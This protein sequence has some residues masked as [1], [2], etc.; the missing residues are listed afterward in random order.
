[1]ALTKVSSSLVS[2]SAVTSGKIA[3]GGV[4]TADIATNAVTSTKIAQNS[5]LTKHIDDGQVTTDQLG[6]DA[7][8]AAKIADNAVSEEHLDITVIT[9]LTAVTAATGDLLMVADVSDSNNLKKIPVSSILAGTH[10]GA[11]NTSGTINSGALGVTGNIAV[12]G[13]VDGI[14]IATRDAVLTSTTTTA[15]AALPKAG[16]TMTGSLVLG[17]ASGTYSHELKFTNGS[18]QAGID[19]QNN[20]DLRF[21]DR[22]SNRVGGYISALNGNFGAYNTSNALTNLLNTNGNSY[23]NGG[24]VGIGTNNPNSTVGIVDIAGAATNY[25]TA[26]MITFEDTAGS[27]N[28]RNWS[29]GN[30]A[31]NYGDFHIGCGDTNS[32]YFD[33]TSHSKFM[34]NKDGNVGIADTTPDQKLVVKNGNI[35]L[36]SNSD[37]NTGIVMFYDATGASSGQIYPVGGDLR[38][39]SPNDVLMMPTGNIGIGTTSPS[40]RLQVNASS[41]I[42]D[43]LI[44]KLDGGETGFSSANDA[45]IKHGLS[46]ELCSYSVST[47]IVQRQAA[48]IEVQKVGSWNEATAGNVGTKADLV[49]STNNGTIATPA[50]AER[51]RID[52]SGNVGIGAT[53]ANSS[54]L[55]LDNGGTSGA[56]QLMLTATGASTQTEIR[57]D[58]SNNLI[59]ENWNSGRTERMRID[60]SGTMILQADGAANLGRIQFSNQA[61][62]YQILG[63]NYIGYM[64]YK[65][66]GYHRWFGSDTAE[67][68]RID[69][70]GN[71]GIGVT[72]PDSYDSRAEK[73]VVGE[74][75][76]AGITIA[77]GASSDCRLVFAV[78]NQTDLSNGSITYDQSIDSMAFETAGSER[79]RIDQ[80]GDM[81]YGGSTGVSEKYFSGSTTGQGTFSH[82]ITHT[83]DGGTG[84]VLHIEAAFTH[85]PAYDCIL[86]TWISRRGT[87]LSHY[88]TRRRDTSTSGSWTVSG[89][90]NTVTRVTKNAGSYIGG[91]PYWIKV[92]WKNHS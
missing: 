15:G 55:R 19:Y 39:W 82:D 86:D 4:A 73:L 8:T 92:T 12:S 6:A 20:G 84:T 26:P 21:I 91:G 22:S 78:T 47:G 43:E 51:M 27:T 85:H 13:T 90:S 60:S 65:T 34:I 25:S 80:S 58:T 66:G 2:D 37:G 83:S 52:S 88:E 72:N 77:G 45:N 87:G 17:N 7:V 74:T 32:D 42:A 59:F 75:G 10:T 89:V 79:M 54:R 71:V 9:S 23:L 57:H 50:I 31:I 64:G 48:K 36:K 18:Y 69:N 62:T 33:A 70:S 61:S 16:G 49:F 41:A 76:D 53:S 5:I 35:K 56:P 11:V 14:D 81:I 68:M 40:T 67:K 28:S 1:M 46:Y 44:L 24:N 3:D 63:G 30:I 38:I 29:I